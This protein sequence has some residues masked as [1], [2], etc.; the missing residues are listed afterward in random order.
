VD[1]LK[2]RKVGNRHMRLVLSSA[3]TPFNASPGFNVSP[4][5]PSSDRTASFDSIYTAGTRATGP[6]LARG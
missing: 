1:S 6:G 2:P 4:G 5:R 3:R